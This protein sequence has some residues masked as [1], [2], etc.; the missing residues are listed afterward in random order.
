L[1]FFG[2]ATTKSHRISSNSVK[3]AFYGG[4]SHQNGGPGFLYSRF[5]A[6]KNPK[7]ALKQA[8]QS[9]TQP[10]LIINNDFRT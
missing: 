7:K 8:A 4:R 5:L 9:L 6:M 3:V 2:N 10:K 1:I